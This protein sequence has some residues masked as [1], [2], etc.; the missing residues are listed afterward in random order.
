MA[1]YKSLMARGSSSHGPRLSILVICLLVLGIL[2]LFKTL[3]MTSDLQ[4]PPQ[5]L[6]DDHGLH[7]EREWLD[8]LEDSP[9]QSAPAHADPAP[10]R[11]QKET[12]LER[13]GSIAMGMQQQQ[14][15]QPAPLRKRPRPR[16]QEPR[17]EQEEPIV[18][19][20]S[21]VHI[22]ET[23][24][25][26]REEEEARAAL[27]K[28][29]QEKLAKRSEHFVAKALDFD[30]QEQVLAAPDGI[31]DPV[32][33]APMDGKL[34]P[35]DSGVV[36]AFLRLSSRR[37][38]SSHASTLLM[39]PTGE[40]HCAWFYGEEGESE[41]AIVMATLRPGVS[42]WEAPRLVSSEPGRSAQNPVLFMLN[43][44][45]IV[46]VHTSQAAG[47][48][49]GT[50]EI[51]MLRSEDG[52]F[53]WTKPKRLFKEAGAMVRNPPIRSTRNPG[54]WLLPLYYTPSGMGHVKDQF[55]VVKRSSRPLS[56]WPQTSTHRIS[57]PGGG[58]VQPA[59]TV[60]PDG[61]ILAF[62]R[63]RGSRNAFSSSSG[64]DGVTWT[65]PRRLPLP[66]NNKAVMAVTL[67][68]GAV[69]LT[70]TNSNAWSKKYPISIAL[71][72]DAGQTW[73]V[74]RDLQAHF[75]IGGCKSG[76]EFSYPAMVFCPGS[77]QDPAAS[78]PGSLHV[79]YTYSR[80]PLVRRAAIR[81]VCIEDPETWVRSGPASKGLYHPG[82][83]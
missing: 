67:P 17:Q 8:S 35:L 6:E 61:R 55:S 77:C 40:L 60:Q 2:V 7:S 76:C 11:R 53:T 19:W 51:R 28:K 20:S 34:R 75:H 50:A 68:S 27:E 64:D 54:E 23:D 10:Y 70:F 82:S 26:K 43:A 3:N 45:T 72:T 36:H 80:A 66:N 1:D 39:T 83:P 65:P 25:R 22:T 49:Q 71:S 24:R 14:Q 69:L 9:L 16:Q 59:L 5:H 15:Q 29:R 13:S 56:S 73:P 42:H 78:G 79:S 33:T 47:R 41:V 46:L 81:Y 18:S 74:V 52:G 62:L 31:R 21:S 63:D 44:T 12:K 57:S 37:P 48:G 4:Q 58:L 38:K 32:N 30:S